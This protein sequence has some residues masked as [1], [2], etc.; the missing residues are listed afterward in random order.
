ML[1]FCIMWSHTGRIV[2]KWPYCKPS[3]DWRRQTSLQPLVLR[4]EISLFWRTNCAW[5]FFKIFCVPKYQLKGGGLRQVEK[6]PSVSP[7]SATGSKTYAGCPRFLR[8]EPLGCPLTSTISP[9]KI[10]NSFNTTEMKNR[11][12]RRSN[13]SC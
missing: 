13:R 2:T 10:F 4:S 7:G 6:M 3:K 11:I 12:F 1:I 5:D 8:T 9:K